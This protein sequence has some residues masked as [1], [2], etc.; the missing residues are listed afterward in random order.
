MTT[1][2]INQVNGRYPEE[3]QPFLGFIA[4]ARRRKE[5]PESPL[6]PSASL[7]RQERVAS[8]F[9]PRPEGQCLAPS[10]DGRGPSRDSLRPTPDGGRDRTSHPPTKDSGSP[11]K[12]DPRS[13]ASLS[14]KSPRPGPASGHQGNAPLLSVAWEGRPRGPGRR[15]T[16]TR[17][18]RNP[19]A[20]RPEDAEVGRCLLSR[21]RQD[22]RAGRDY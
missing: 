15:R 2:R 19:I 4:Q 5:E 18:R 11:V 21:T 13:K 3:N 6:P 14:P 12:G 20:R 9:P 8:P 10:A 1:G 7:I 17:S 16:N 22:T